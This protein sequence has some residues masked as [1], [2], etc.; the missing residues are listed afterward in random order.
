MIYSGKYFWNDNIGSREFN[1]YPLWVANY[2]VTCPDMSDPWSNWTIWQ[3]GDNRTVPGISGAV[4]ADKFNGTLDDLKALAGATPPLDMG[5]AEPAPDARKNDVEILDGEVPDGGSD[6]APEASEPT[7]D[8]GS[9]AVT[10]DAGAATPSTEADAAAPL[11]A[12]AGVEGDSGCA[13]RVATRR[14]ST[15][16]YASVLLALAHAMLRRRVRRP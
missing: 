7:A 10:P 13:C 6:E 8:A 15:A 11:V 4:D 1:N 16:P 12:A 9:P 5:D 3:Y 14:Q 2:G